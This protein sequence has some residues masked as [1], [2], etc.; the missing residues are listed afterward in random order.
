MFV[1][2]FHQAAATAAWVAAFIQCTGFGN[3]ELSTTSIVQTAPDLPLFESH[4]A[5]ATSE[6]V[7]AVSPGYIRNVQGDCETGARRWDGQKGSWLEFRTWIVSP[8]DAT[9]CAV[10]QLAGDSPIKTWNKWASRPEFVGDSRNALW[11]LGN[12]RVG[13]K[14]LESRASERCWLLLQPDGDG[15]REFDAY[16]LCSRVRGA[17]IPRHSPSSI[18]R[19]NL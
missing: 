16:Y 4:A 5:A 17:P 3:Q 6:S 7:R 10:R 14:R 18:S 11:L 13:K 19:P 15:R 1:R 2:H 12:V 8:A 9:E